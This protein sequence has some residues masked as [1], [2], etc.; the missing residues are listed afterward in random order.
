MFKGILSSSDLR[1]QYPRRL[2]PGLLQQSLQLRQHLARWPRMSSWQ[3][4]ATIPL[5]HATPL[6]RTTLLSRGLLPM[7]LISFI[8]SP[9]ED[10]GETRQP[11]GRE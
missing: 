7:R 5:S 3:S 6:W 11:T 2:L 8:Q 10:E 4:A 1:T 9:G